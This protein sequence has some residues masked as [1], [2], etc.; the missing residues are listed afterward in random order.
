MRTMRF[1]LIMLAALLG[2]MPAAVHAQAPKS[3]EAP[4]LGADREVIFVEMS[5][6]STKGPPLITANIMGEQQT[7]KTRLTDVGVYSATFKVPFS[8]VLPVE[9]RIGNGP[10]T[11]DL[12][13]LHHSD[14]RVS[15]V[16]EENG[17]FLRSSSPASRESMAIQEAMILLG[18]VLWI[19]VVGIALISGRLERKDAKAVSWTLSEPI[20]LLFWLGLAVAWTWPSVL[21]S[22]SMVVGRHFDTVGT[23]W[24]IGSASRL[25]SHL[26][27]STAWP[28]GADLTRLDSYLLVPVSSLLSYL[29]PG[30]IFG[31]LSIV[32]VAMNAWAAQ[33]FAR[34][35]GARSP[36]TLLAGIGF[37]FCGMAATGLLEGHIYQVFNPWLPWFGAMLWRSTSI[38]GTAKHTCLTLALFILCW[39][40]TAY[41]GVVALGMAV[42]LMLM[43]ERKP[44]G[45]ILGGVGFLAA[46]VLWYTHG[47]A[48]ARETLEGLNPMSAHMAGLLAATPEID[49]VEHSMA[50]IVFGW[51]LGLVILGWH[52][53]EKGR[54]RALLFAGVASILLSMIPGF[55]ASP[56]LVLIPANLDWVPGPI[57]GFLRFPIRWAWLWSLCGGVLAALVATRMAPRWGRWGWAVLLIAVIEAFVRIGT[58]YRQEMR[59]IEAP[60]KLTNH[61]GGVLELLPITENR[62]SNWDR[63][64]SNFSCL[65]QLNHQQPIAED[66]VHT[67]PRKIRHQLNVW[68]Q[69]R[70]LREDMEGAEAT[71]A[72]L[73]FRTVML[74]P[75]L[76][77]T[78][79]AARMEQELK[80]IDAH[81]DVVHEKGVHAVLFTIRGNANQNIEAMLRNLKPPQQ[82]RVSRRNWMGS[83]H[84]GRFNGQV[85]IGGWFLI[86]L[87]LGFSMRRRCSE[88]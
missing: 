80:K 76:F 53:L 43:S 70:L 34:A 52:V 17:D 54:W 28:I 84:H 16:L 11:E 37:G 36:W 58:P 45:L 68:L 79:H 39:L 8:R 21:S 22:N 6:W 15:W 20:W 74:K 49:R 46:Y 88:K 55:A 42:V 73:N 61:D 87:V 77:T 66:C 50:P 9:L 35:V 44:L 78:Q 64:M 32:G 19:L 25:F 81:P 5:V 56:D 83:A 1:L 18:G 7:Q 4:T 59:F 10:V 2:L 62:G 60:A 51:M 31:W 13:V 67:K 82:P 38:D 40:T 48:P 63:W 26:D 24:V 86:F 27:P 69:D 47:D 12:I 71:L 14:H 3:W 29:G 30:R 75:D 41:V 72:A 33:H 23:L 65:E 57:A 85:A